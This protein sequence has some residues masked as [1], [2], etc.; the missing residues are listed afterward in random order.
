MP[1]IGQSFGQRFEPGG[2]SARSVTPGTGSSGFT[3]RSVIIANTSGQLDQD[4][5]NFF[6]ST[7]GPYLHVATT[8]A[9][10]F[11][12][13]I[14]STAANSSFSLYVRGSTVSGRNTVLLEREGGAAFFLRDPLNNTTVTITQTNAA[15]NALGVGVNGIDNILY[16]STAGGGAVGIGTTA[17]SGP[18]QVNSGSTAVLVVTTA[19]RVGIGTTAPDARF[20]LSGAGSQVVKLTDTAGVSTMQIQQNGANSSR[21]DIILNNYLVFGATTAALGFF[22]TTPVARPSSYTPTAVTSG[23]VLPTTV[24]TGTQT[25]VQVLALQNA[26]NQLIGVVRTLTKD[27]AGYGL[28]ST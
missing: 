22:N 20:Q 13:S 3:S 16:V 6:Y 18:L 19:N 4:V 10:T 5:A 1:M 9:T 27:F 7:A 14:G 15:N 26:M 12:V 17:P 25:T 24:T 11:G 28:L 8:A 2:E 23:R 21:A